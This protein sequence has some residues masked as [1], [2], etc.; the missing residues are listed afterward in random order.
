[1]QHQWNGRGRQYIAHHVDVV[2]VKVQLLGPFSIRLGEERAGPWPRPSAKRLCELLLVRPDHRLLKEVAREVLFAGLAPDASANALGRA[3]SM[4]RQALSALG[5]T[6]PRLL[7]ADR[8][9]IWV[10]ENIHLEVDLVT[11]DAALRRALA[12]EP[13]PKRDGALST[14]LLQDG[15]LLEDEPYSD[16][17]LE[18]RDALQLLHQRARL[19]LARD[20]ADG[21]G[22]SEPAAVIDA[23]ESCLAHDPASEESAAALM[24]AHSALGQR[25][26]VVRTY[27][28][29]R[30]ALEDLGL[31]PSAA[32]ERTYSSAT[33]D[34]LKLVAPGTTE[35]FEWVTNVSTSLANSSALTKDGSQGRHSRTRGRRYLCRHS[36]APLSR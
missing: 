10:P 11:H 4:A 16:W 8:C 23:W 9:H 25:Q 18:P 31:K 33:A 13:G 27:R 24:R 22:R 35:R 17:A 1:M 20:R 19:E 28:R 26:L 36:P 2:P 21:H 15:L 29:C 14:A 30:D 6:G 3:A 7:Q 34:M 32:L 5:E 12:M